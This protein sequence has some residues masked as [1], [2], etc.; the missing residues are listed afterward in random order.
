MS[1]SDEDLWFLDEEEEGG[2][3]KELEKGKEGGEGVGGVG[4]VGV[5]GVPGGAAAR[6]AVAPEPRAGAPRF[7][8]ARAGVYG[9]G[10]SLTAR[11]ECVVSWLA[12]V[13]MA[14]VDDVA[15]L[16]GYF[17]GRGEPVSKQLASRWFRR[18]SEAQLVGRIAPWTGR[19]M[20]AF[21][22]PAL[23]GRVPSTARLFGQTARHE[24]L[25]AGVSARVI[26]GGGVWE[27]IRFEHTPGR[28]GRRPHEADGYEVDV[29]TGERVAVEVELSAKSPERLAKIVKE[30]AQRVERG[31]YR[32]VRYVCTERAARAV[33]RAVEA[34]VWPGGRGA[35]R[36]EVAF[37]ERGEWL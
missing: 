11:D 22:M 7:A 3:G 33:A 14:S 8:G 27:P 16:L 13:G 15:L 34:N 9:A 25:V 12:D 4:G 29:T 21:P 30:H 23:G 24:A 1:V 26:A 5:S 36:V 20:I 35:F 28:R 10:V 31:E 19:S 17:G 37:T 32:A 6:G 2:E 18:M